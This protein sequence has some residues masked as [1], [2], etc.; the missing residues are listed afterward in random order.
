MTGVEALWQSM[1]IANI[2]WGESLMMTVGPLPVPGGK[3]I[4]R[5]STA[6]SGDQ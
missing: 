4:G 2:T 5:R 3:R 6:L 1:G